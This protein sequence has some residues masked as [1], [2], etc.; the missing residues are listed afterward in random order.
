MPGDQ[1]PAINKPKGPNKL[2]QILQKA[3]KGAEKDPTIKQKFQKV[4]ND[5]INKA[6]IILNK[7]DVPATEDV[8]GDNQ[9]ATLDNLINNMDGQEKKEFDELA[10]NTPGFADIVNKALELSTKQVQKIGTELRSLINQVV[11]KVIGSLEAIEDAY[12]EQEKQGEIEPGASIRQGAQSIGD[13]LNLTINGIAG[14]LR[15][16][17][18]VKSQTLIAFLKQCQQSGIIDLTKLPTEGNIVRIAMQNQKFSDL[19]QTQVT[20]GKSTRRFI[21]W[22]MQIKPGGSGG[23][24][25]GPGETGLAIMGTP[26]KKGKKGDLDVGGETIEIKASN[27]KKSGGRIGTEVVKSGKAGLPEYMKAVKELQRTVN[28]PLKGGRISY[29]FTTKS[30]KTSTKTT[31]IGNFSQTTVYALNQAIANS[32]KAS[33]QRQDITRFL[34]S[35]ANSALTISQGVKEIKTDMEGAVD[36]DNKINFNGFMREY[37]R[38]ILQYYNQI[39]KVGKILI[40]NPTTGNYQ[41]IHATDMNDVIKK[42]DRAGDESGKIWTSTSVM[43]FTD[44]TAKLSPQLGVA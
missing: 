26:V 21:D 16:N 39:E 6:K 33:V 1:P 9:L 30:G 12:K 41:T 25:W 5:L 31:L 14:F 42:M 2:G 28:I 19:L 32:P 23:G 20:V 10:K 11:G 40:I 15:Q 3:S 44:G 38:V 43:N 8:A 35:V 18:P 36:P 29:T 22:L 17:D 37:L 13:E 7:P 24:N 4:V 27:D 34:T